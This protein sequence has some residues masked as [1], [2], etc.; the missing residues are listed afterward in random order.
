M[1]S[2][3]EG[4]IVE[5]SAVNITPLDETATSINILR[6]GPN[7]IHVA[8]GCHVWQTTG[9]IKSKVESTTAAG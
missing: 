3:S 5:S 6:T 8:L 2:Q 1:A 4:K 7:S 9:D